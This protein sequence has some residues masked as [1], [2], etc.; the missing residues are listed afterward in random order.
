MVLPLF[1][2]K[3]PFPFLRTPFNESQGQFSPDG[4][5]IAYVSNDSGPSQVY[6]APFP[7]RGG[8]AQ[9]ST[10]GGTS[11]RWRH[12]G[13]ELFY[14]AADLKLMAAVVNGQRAG[15]E[16]GTVQPLF[17]VRPPLFRSFYDASLD[18]QRF[19]VNNLPEQTTA[20]PITVVLNW[21]AGLKE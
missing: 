3:K 15:F 2:D 7:G 16:V 1:G 20:S 21:T 8:K 6:V 12:D 4:R 5:W 11:P 10:G 13:K 17:A 18:G 9:V 14:V 19:L